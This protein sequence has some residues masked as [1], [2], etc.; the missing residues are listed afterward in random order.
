MT[1]S[2]LTN[3]CA[4]QDWGQMCRFQGKI[5]SH[6]GSFTTNLLG[7]AHFSFRPL[8]TSMLEQPFRISCVVRKEHKLFSKSKEERLMAYQHMHFDESDRDQPALYAAGYE[9]VSR[10]QD[11]AFGPAG[12]KLSGQEAQQA[13]TTAQRL[14]LAIVSLV[15]LMLI[16]FAIATVALF[17]P[18]GSSLAAVFAIMFLAFLVACIVINVVFNRRR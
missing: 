3:G 2:Q 7:K 5:R 15:L 18:I 14:A 4:A 1:V 6:F 8:D 10:D 11:E 16:F 13:P 17:H 12:Q 9:E